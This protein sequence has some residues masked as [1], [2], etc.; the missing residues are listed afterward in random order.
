METRLLIGGELVAG[1]GPALTVENPATEATIADV[2][3]AS[4]EQSKVRFFW[5]PPPGGE[6]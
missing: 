3:A 2:P 4:S 5:S 1:D 6:G